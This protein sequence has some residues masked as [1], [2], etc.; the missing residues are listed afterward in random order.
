MR[1]IKI[2]GLCLVAVLALVAVAASSASA[3]EPEWAGCGPQK[4]GNFTE[5]KCA[6]VAEKHGVPDHKGHYEFKSGQAATCLAQKHGN[7]TEEKCETVATKHGVPD[8]K[9]HYEKAPQD[10][11]KGEGG[12]GILETQWLEC[13]ETVEEGYSE[14]GYGTRPREDCGGEGVGWEL[15]YSQVECES[16]HATGEAT[17]TKEVVNISVRFI[18]CTHSGTPA[19]T[20]PSTS[21]SPTCVAGEIETNK[22]KGRLG[23]INKANHEVGVLLEPATGTLFAT[24]EAV[25]GNFLDRVGVGNATEGSFYEEKNAPVPAGSDGTGNDGIISPIVPVNTMTR[26]F[27]QNYS[28]EAPPYPCNDLTCESRIE[29]I[30]AE[31]DV[32]YLNKPSHF[33][34]GPFEELENYFENPTTR[35]CEKNPPPPKTGCYKSNWSSSGEEITNVNTVEGGYAEIKA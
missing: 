35:D 16:E 28:V 23:Y 11:F 19:T 34:G 20:V 6:T 14:A 30:Q 15:S 25:N 7:Y 22:L 31:L 3:A 17:G 21:C 8:H 10:K 4:H 32:A 24:F 29:P 27:T 18:G 33:E 1:H 9:G 12:A 26:T 5:E 13:D 2:M